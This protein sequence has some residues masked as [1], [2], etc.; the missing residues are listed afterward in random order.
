MFAN[1]IL[2]VFTRCFCVLNELNEF[3]LLISSIVELFNLN[4]QTHVPIA[5]ELKMI[6]INSS[7]W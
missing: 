5:H 3:I 1:I 2:E 7:V 6:K 4:K